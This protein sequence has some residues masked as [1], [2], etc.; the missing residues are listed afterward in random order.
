MSTPPESIFRPGLFAGR[1]ALITGGG[2]GIGKAIGFE[3]GRLGCRLV[4]A[5][6]KQERLDAAVAAFTEQGLEA[7]SAVCNIRDEDQV[8]AAV[9]TAL[10]T[11]GRLDFV[12]NNAGGQFPSPAGQIRT[13]GWKAVIETNLTGT[14]LVCREAYNAWFEE[15]GGAIV[16]IIA[17]MHRGFPGMAHTGAARAGVDNLTKSLAIEWAHNGIRVNAVA[18]GIIF[19]SGYENYDPFFQQV[20]LDMRKNIP[21]QR[22]GTEEE[23]ASSVVFLL[24]PAAAF[25]SGQTLGV[26]GAGSLWR[27][28]WEVPEHDKM[29]RFGGVEV[30]ESPS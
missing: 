18:P 30:P 3:L 14:F 17:D 13:K 9:K 4:L 20:F 26:D 24:S 22:L 16:N 11:W 25:I 27:V 10:D 2:S 5:A 21:A 28:N 12:V 6:R 8:A 7:V 19:G 1:V 23:V 29:P 15:H